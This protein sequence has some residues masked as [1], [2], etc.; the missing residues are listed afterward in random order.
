MIKSVEIQGYQS[1]LDTKVEFSSGVNVITGTSNHGKSAFFRSLEWAITGR[2]L[3]WWFKSWW[4]KVNQTN[5]MIETDKGWAIKSKSKTEN[6]YTTQD[7]T[8]ECVKGDVPDE[9]KNILGLTDINLQGQHKGY[10]MLNDSPGQVASAFN[11][12]IGLE[13]IDQVMS[14]VDSIVRKTKHD[15]SH[16]QDQLA[17][18]ITTLE[19]YKN[20]DDILAKLAELKSLDL[21]IKE[22]SKV[23]ALVKDLFGQYTQKELSLTKLTKW[24]KVE[25]YYQKVCYCLKTKEEIETRISEVKSLYERLSKIKSTINN[26][27]NM[28]LIEPIVEDATKLSKWIKAYTNKVES[29][30]LTFKRFEDIRGRI[31]SENAKIGQNLDEYKGI[32]QEIKI[33]PTCK[34][35]ITDDILSHILEVL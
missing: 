35:N 32:L 25:T 26:I 15:L 13:I 33:C 7:S 16:T 20:L 9:V 1:H 5:V 6:K 3:G 14:N 31:E 2:P 29:L 19:K 34:S 28:L 17:K 10:F 11:K 4:P 22:Q 30:K 18:T 27:D 23:L 8:F 21:E 24:L 12:A